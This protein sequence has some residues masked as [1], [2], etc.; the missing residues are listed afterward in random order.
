MDQYN[1][2]TNVSGTLYGNMAAAQAQQFS[3]MAT[4]ARPPGHLDTVYNSLVGI[5]DS[6]N[7]VS[8]T[9]WDTRDR[10]FGSAAETNGKGALEPVRAG[11]TG[12]IETMLDA[13]RNRVDYIRELSNELQSRL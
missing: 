4:K 10:L 3:G 11:K 12:D 6:L 5:S 1:T 13:L 9:L 2:A 7:T 8:T